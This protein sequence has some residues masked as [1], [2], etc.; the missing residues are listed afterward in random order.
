MYSFFEAVDVG[1]RVQVRRLGTLMKE[2]SWQ[3][4]GCTVDSFSNAVSQVG[5]YGRANT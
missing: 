4:Q 3:T 2:L 5:F 1:S